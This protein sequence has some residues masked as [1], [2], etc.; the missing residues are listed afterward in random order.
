MSR[1]PSV[2]DP[3]SLWITDTSTS[4]VATARTLPLIVLIRLLCAMSS[5]PSTLRSIAPDPRVTRSP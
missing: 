1:P 2:T 4:P 5:C 3:L